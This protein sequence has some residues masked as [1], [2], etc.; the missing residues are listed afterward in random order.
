VRLVAQQLGLATE[1]VRL[2]VRCDG[3]GGAG[4]EPLLEMA[5]WQSA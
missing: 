4:G 5:A 3:E 1:L 2:T